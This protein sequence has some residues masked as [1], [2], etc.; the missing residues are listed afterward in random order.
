MHDKRCLIH[1]SLI[2]MQDI[3]FQSHLYSFHVAFTERRLN[4]FNS[5]SNFVIAGRHG[6]YQYCIVPLN[7]TA[8]FHDPAIFM[9]QFLLENEQCAWSH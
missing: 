7:F 1:T 3:S 8:F 9:N 5:V 4:L 6:Q 2:T